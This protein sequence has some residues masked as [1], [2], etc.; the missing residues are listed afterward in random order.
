LTFSQS[1]PNPQ[2][3]A[4]CLHL[5]SYHVTLTRER[6]PQLNEP[7]RYFPPRMAPDGARMRI[8]HALW[9]PKHWLLSFLAKIYVVSSGGLTNTLLLFIFG[10]RV[11]VGIHDTQTRLC[12]LLMCGV[13]GVGER[14]LGF[15]ASASGCV[16]GGGQ[17]RWDAS[18]ELCELELVDVP[19][20]RCM[21]LVI[22]GRSA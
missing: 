16:G 10:G 22:C 9:C 15:C 20:L 1:P 4:A 17:G 2:P 19:W 7:D 8:P 13:V 21:G 12:G 14:H 5:S 6:N 18:W 11:F 3:A